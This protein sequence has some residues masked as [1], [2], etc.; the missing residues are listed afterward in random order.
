M[1]SAEFGG[2]PC[3]ECNVAGIA[4]KGYT[5]RVQNSGVLVLPAGKVYSFD[6]ETT[7]IE[8]ENRETVL[9]QFYDDS[10]KEVLLA[11]PRCLLGA[12]LSGVCVVGHYL[13]FDFISLLMSGCA[14]LPRVEYDTFLIANIYQLEGSRGLKEL[15]FSRLGVEMKHFD[16]KDAFSVVGK[17]EDIPS[18]KLE[19]ACEDVV[20]SWRL[21]EHMK[22]MYSKSDVARLEFDV[23]PHFAYM[24]FRGLPLDRVKL[25]SL[26][27]QLLKEQDEAKQK[28]YAIA[29]KEFNPAS[30]KQMQQILF[31]ERGLVPVVMT[32]K[33]V[34]STSE[35]ALS[36]FEGDELVDA[37]GEYKKAAGANSYF[38][39]LEGYGS[40]VLH[41]YYKQV[42]FD[43]TSRVY[44]ESPSTNQMP[45]LIRGCIHPREGM[46][47]AYV[48][49]CAAELIAVAY[50]AEET[51]LLE[52]NESGEDV[53][54]WL[55][56]KLLEG[57]DVPALSNLTP[58]KRRA[59]SK[60]VAF[61]V[62]YGSKGN[63]VS[64]KLKVS[65]NVAERL[66]ERFF[67][68]LPKIKSYR[69]S[70]VEE[71]KKRGYT[72]TM[73]GRRRILTDG[74]ND[75]SFARK[76]FNTAIQGT[77][78][79]L[80]KMA[81]REMSPK[82]EKIGGYVLTTVF[83]SFL[84][85]IPISADKDEVLNIVD[86]CSKCCV[87]FRFKAAFAQSWLEAMESAS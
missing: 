64:L 3:E 80:Q 31:T 53:H 19:Y 44:T 75:A 86:G 1:K 20:Q 35:D 25:A 85:E 32:P 22:Q 74:V 11:H 40:S 4:D 77:V 5:I 14:K 45:K 9:F 69:D 50:M 36:Y 66:V 61:A 73:I 54:T 60:T 33:G 7:D 13:G 57:L 16:K 43:G 12:D 8:Y 83:D 71:A 59:I 26:K 42:G 87:P 29:G 58:E 30:P 79:D 24:S 41:P 6:S 47:F 72:K 84:I 46:Q 67:E 82:L 51:S 56:A 65:Q 39:T 49:W 63:S 68:V 18:E 17:V 37:L 10:E 76:A 21:Y 52:V 48:D 15:V 23:L 70:L 28:M 38:S 78:A 55:S 62:L 34:P 81:L 27:E 2:A